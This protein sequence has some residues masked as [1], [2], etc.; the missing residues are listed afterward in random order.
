MFNPNNLPKVLTEKML[1][2]FA[3]FGENGLPELQDLGKTLVEYESVG[4]P[5]V[6]TFLDTQSHC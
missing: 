4:P 2:W 3:S 6:Q 1:H 5:R